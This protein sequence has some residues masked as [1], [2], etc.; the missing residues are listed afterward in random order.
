[1]SVFLEKEFYEML[2][3]KM[4]AAVSISCL[5]AKERGVDIFL[6]GGIVRDIILGNEI[7]D[8]DIAVQS[9]AVGFCEYL[10]SKYDCKIESTQ[11]KL[12]TSKVRFN[13]NVVIDFA[14]TRE[15]KYDSPGVLPSAFNFGCPLNQDVKRRDFTINTLAIK[16]TGDDK[17]KLIDY[18]SGYEDIKNKQIRI[19]HKNSFVDDPSRIIRALKFKE[20][21]DFMIEPETY[22]IMQSYLNNISKDIPLERIKNEFRQY[23]MINKEN[24]YGEIIKSNVYKLISDNPLKEINTNRIKKM[25]NLNIFKKTEIWFLYV[26]CLIIN[27]NCT[28]INLNMTAFENKII[29]ETQNMILSGIV[30]INDNEKIYKKYNDK[31]DL[32]LALYFVISG[33]ESVIKFLN[34][35]KQIKV[36]I[37]GNDLIELGFIPSKYF[38]EIFE[39]ILKEKLKGLLKTKEEEINFVKRHI[40]KQSD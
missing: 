20:R 13:N 31:I 7:K 3:E 33:D 23:F 11:E 15:E 35:L 19:L 28:D 40:K 30:D 18:Y 24:I 21:L 6:I 27:S 26:A 38:S 14:S 36:L 32:S 29:S 9:D 37:N 10:A 12:R 2:S 1:M 39:N 17:Y 22:S 8:I 25:I 4:K 34:V 16:L 5:A